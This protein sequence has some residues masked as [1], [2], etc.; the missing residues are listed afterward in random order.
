M[1]LRYVLPALALA[2]VAVSAEAQVGV[3]LNPVVTRISNSTPDNGAF[4]FLGNGVT[5]RTFGGLDVGGYYDLTHEP[6]LKFGVDVRDTIVHANNASLDTFS[7]GG[8]VEASPIAYR[9]RPYAELYAG[10][11]RSKAALSV[12]HS[13]R[14]AFG[15]LAGLD[16]PLNR[17]VD[18]RVVELGFGSVTTT[19]SYIYGSPPAIGASTQ[20]SVSSGLV[21]RFR[22]PGGAPKKPKQTY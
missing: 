20:F 15:V 1:R 11:A 8:R 22:V 12:V 19:N 5:S 3:Y 2:V 10:A 4:S 7:V 13:T 9:L 14:A 6:G 21:F 18:F 17:H 16:L